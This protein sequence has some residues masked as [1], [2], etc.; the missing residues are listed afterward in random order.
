MAWNAW[1]EEPSSRPQAKP[2]SIEAQL[3]WDYPLDKWTPAGREKALGKLSIT[4][5][6]LEPWLRMI[7]D[8]LLEADGVPRHMV[9]PILQTMLPAP[10]HSLPL[11]VA[12]PE[13]VSTRTFFPFTRLPTELRWKIWALAAD[14]RPQIIDFTTRIC[15]PPLN[16][17]RDMP[18]VASAC[19]EAWR[20]FM[21][22]GSYW[23]PLWTADTRRQP[24][25]WASDADIA[26]L[27]TPRHQWRDII[28]M[29]TPPRDEP[30][31]WDPDNWDKHWDYSFLKSRKTLAV[32][33]DHFI[34]HAARGGQYA[35]LRDS[36][37]IETI[38][39][40]RPKKPCVNITMDRH[41]C[42]DCCG[43]PIHEM[44]YRYRIWSHWYCCRQRRLKH[45]IQLVMYDEPGELERVNELWRGLD[46]NN[47]WL[48]RDEDYE[49]LEASSMWDERGVATCVDCEREHGQKMVADAR[50]AWLELVSPPTS[51]P[52]PG[53]EEEE[54]EEE[55]DEGRRQ[56]R[57]VPNFRL[58]VAMEFYQH[59]M[60][61]VRGDDVHGCSCVGDSAALQGLWRTMKMKSRRI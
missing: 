26:Y 38:I 3:D 11:P 13:D 20:F 55:E 51:S 54:R 43:P 50:R 30:A 44:E 31:Y 10:Y 4:P 6:Q 46:P 48:Y 35:W 40:V 61:P 17:A 57:R 23:Q 60:V 21:A 59:Q 7:R 19:K 49:H 9:Q 8:M 42:R 16:G 41:T 34:D 14:R 37:A 32:D 56:K 45:Q 47:L 24:K 2:P 36:E 12:G 27:R 33:Y 15:E 18:T 53:N 28:T 25:Y 52:V 58:A 29:D 5:E 39:L 22:K 1:N